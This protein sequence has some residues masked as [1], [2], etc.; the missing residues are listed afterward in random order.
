MCT[1]CVVGIASF[2]LLIWL[3]ISRG[4]SGQGGNV[5]KSARV[6]LATPKN[7]IFLVAIAY[8]LGNWIKAG[9]MRGGIR[10]SLR[11][12]IASNLFQYDILKRF[13]LQERTTHM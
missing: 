8:T 5:F 12:Q 11:W 13:R 1:L 4:P 6:D 9:P 3:I 2:G 10:K 7:G